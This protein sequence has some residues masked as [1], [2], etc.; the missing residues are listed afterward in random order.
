VY[1]YLLLHFKRLKFVILYG[2]YL[3]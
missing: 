3:L 2:S 1:A